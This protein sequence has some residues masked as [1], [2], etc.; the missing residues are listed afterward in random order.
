MLDTQ[1]EVELPEDHKPYT[2]KYFL[3]SRQILEESGINPR[4]AI[5]VF[6]RGEGPV[7][8]DG[9]DEAVD[10]IETY[11]PDFADNGGE[12]WTTEEDTF[13]T[14]DPLMV[15]EGQIQDVIELETMYLGVLSHHLTVAHP[16]Y[17][18]PTLTEFEENVADAVDVYDAAGRTDG[19]DSVPLLYFG[20]RHYHP[21]MDKELAGAALGAGA[22]QTS[23]DIGS[24][25][26]GEEG[27][28]TTPHILALSIAS[29]YGKEDATRKMAELYDTHIGE[30]VGTTLIDTFNQ[31]VDDALAVCEY[32]DETYGEGNWQH[33]FRIDTCGEN[34]GQGA[35]DADVSELDLNLD[36]GEERYLD[37]SGVR[38]AG[39]KAVRDA[40]IE[41]GYG[42]NTEIFLS[43]GMGDPV[44]A[45]AFIEAQNAYVEETGY[46]LFAGVG[47]GAFVDGVH[48]TADMYAAGGELMYKTGRPVDLDDIETYKQEHMKKAI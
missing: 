26:I 19:S 39:V 12:V 46:D 14:K 38:I 37:G 29:E 15:I 5:K 40:L 16:E 4:V 36:E 2:D 1:N 13:S 42:D 10:V 48:G 28:G 21:L 8:Q 43:S 3:K 22:V 31:E 45:S 11:A 34:V 20:A 30:A 27:T 33:N 23:T 24:S 41:H 17:D 25:N 44:K 32:F 18:L 9:L 35:E 47:A 6:A 7:P